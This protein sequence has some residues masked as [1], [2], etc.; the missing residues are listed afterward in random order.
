MGASLAQIYLFVALYFPQD[1]LNYLE[2][3]FIPFFL[4]SAWDWAKLSIEAVLLSKTKEPE[5]L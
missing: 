1:N 4:M 5:L 3:K 2:S